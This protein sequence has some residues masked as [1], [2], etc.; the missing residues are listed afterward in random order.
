M[1]KQPKLSKSKQ[2]AKA[3]NRLKAIEAT[4]AWREQHPRSVRHGYTNW[5]E[6][7]IW[8]SMKQRCTN[9]RHV[10]W[11][12]YGGRGIKVCKQWVKSFPAFL[13]DLGPRPSAGHSLDRINVNGDYEPANV[14]WATQWEQRKNKREKQEPKR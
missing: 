10:G 7:E 11:M 2:R 14:R 12:N 6:Y 13:W 8:K 3:G 5:E 4:H 9:P 1:V